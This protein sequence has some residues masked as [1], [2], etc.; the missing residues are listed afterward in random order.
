MGSGIYSIGVSALKV[1]QAGISVTSHNIANANTPGYTRQEILQSAALP[2][3]TGAG[4]FGQGADVTSVKRNYDEFLSAQVGEAQTRSSSLNTQYALS[5]QVSNLLGDPNGGLTPALQDFFGS[6]N[7]VANAP[8]SVAA[9]QTMIGSA[10]SLSNRLQSLDSRLTEIRNGLNG[11]ITNSTA[12]INSYAKQIAVLND[13]IVRAKALSG[14]NQ[15]PNDLLDQRDQLLTQLS[16]EIC[17][18]EVT[19]IS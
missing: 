5:Q 16:Q 4:F 7:T 19:R 15:A 6:I 3:N 11:Q 18:T 12:N 9:R 13:N 14:P 17:F 1:A 8:E 2:Q 10:Q